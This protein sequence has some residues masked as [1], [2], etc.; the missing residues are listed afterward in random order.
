M[1]PHY[2]EEEDDS[3]LPERL[4]AILKALADYHTHLLQKNT[5]ETQDPNHVDKVRQMLKEQAK[6]ILFA[7]SSGQTEKIQDPKL[8]EC[9]Q[10]L[11]LN[12]RPYDFE[13]DTLLKYWCK[14]MF[15][16]YPFIIAHN[17]IDRF[18]KNS[19]YKEEDESNA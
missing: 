9:I 11:Q 4:K 13:V 12:N 3:R 2:V 15:V 19:L 18:L 14:M 10:S 7:L 5:L 1:E 17:H 8:S 6:V 16:E